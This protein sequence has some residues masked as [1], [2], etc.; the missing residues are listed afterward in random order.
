[1]SNPFI[2]LV[3]DNLKL[4]NYLKDFLTRAGYQV[5]QQIR[6]DKAVYQIIKNQ[7]DIVI[8]DIMLPGFNGIQVCQSVRDRYH[9]MILMLTALSDKADQISGLTGGADDYV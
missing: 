3:E 6:G 5:T 4:S 7:P 8:L 9:G 1:M 2:L